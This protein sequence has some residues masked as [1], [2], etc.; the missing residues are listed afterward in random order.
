VTAHAWEFSLPPQ[1]LQRGFWIYAWKI[2]GPRDE[3]L[4]YVGM[5]GDVTRVAQSPFGRATSTLGDNKNANTLRKTLE[6]KGIDPKRCK[7][8]TLA[9]YGPLYDA[10]DSKHFMEHWHKVRSLERALFDALKDDGFEPIN[11][12]RP[13]GRPDYDPKMLDSIRAAFATHFPRPRLQPVA[14]NGLPQRIVTDAGLDPRRY[15]HSLFRYRCRRR[16]EP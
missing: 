9:A 13:D 4:C 5:T 2:V 8:L 11:R 1:L 12:R 7:A 16:R 6:A 15:S 3:H 10:D 14:G